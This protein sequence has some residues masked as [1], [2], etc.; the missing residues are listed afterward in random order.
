MAKPSARKKRY[1]IIRIF[2]WILLLFLL[3]LSLG[4]LFLVSR[5]ET[6]ENHPLESV[7]VNQFTDENIGDYIN[8]ALFGV[9][10]QQNDL[11][12][13]T[14]S[15]SM[16]IAS[17]NRKTHK[18]TLTSL[19]R[20]TYVEIEGHGM[21]KLNHAYAFGGPELAVNTINTNFDLNI[22]DFV[23]VNFMALANTIDALGGIRINITEEELDWVNAYSKDVARINGTKFKKIKRAGKQKLNG[24]Q[25]TGYCR[26]RYTSGGDFTRAKR[27]RRV[28]MAIFRKAKKAD[29]FT[30]LEVMNTIFPQIYTS[31]ST[32][33]M[34]ALAKYLPW[35]E[36]EN[37]KGFPYELDCHRAGDGIYYD[38][39][40]TLT[41]NVQK[42]HK[43]LFGTKNYQPSQKVSEIDAAISLDAGSLSAAGGY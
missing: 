28:I 40:V 42:L 27:Q 23:T 30:L 8:I 26:V 14:R 12:E 34:L 36:I 35:Y 10:S 43:K 18:V 1:S 3:L 39:P 11:Q 22:Q 7:A 2:L 5:L 29:P 38:F 21:T 37:Q 19:Y 33:D 13:N 20:D 24:T 9:D 15:D 6:I 32:K 25:A 17:V 16:I 4:I 41:T 31:L